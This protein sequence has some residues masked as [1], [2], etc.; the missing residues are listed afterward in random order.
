MLRISALVSSREAGGA[1]SLQGCFSCDRIQPPE[2]PSCFKTMAPCWGL[3]SRG[4]KYNIQS[5]AVSID[6]VDLDHGSHSVF[7]NEH[8]HGAR[9]KT[10][11]CSVQNGALEPGTVSWCTAEACRMW[12]GPYSSSCLLG[13]T[14]VHPVWCYPRSM[15]S[16]QTKK[17][18]IFLSFIVL[19]SWS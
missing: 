17:E 14:I 8:D 1:Q 15:I 12:T 16:K 3:V 10:L 5:D 9:L 6:N 11:S 19:F 7:W 2:S 13:C 4:A 18:S